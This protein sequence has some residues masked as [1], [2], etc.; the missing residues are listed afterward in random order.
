M[1]I[2][3]LSMDAIF[4]DTSGRPTV[5]DAT[6]RFPFQKLQHP[7]VRKGSSPFHGSHHFTL[8][9]YLILPSKEVSS[10]ILNV[11]GIT[12]PEIEPRS[13]R[14]LVNTSDTLIQALCLTLLKFPAGNLF[15]SSYILILVCCNGLGLFTNKLSF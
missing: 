5:V 7:D 8:D 6:R 12:R 9:T 14:P 1:K 3:I 2:H 15:R 13:P 11:F 10:T 4:K